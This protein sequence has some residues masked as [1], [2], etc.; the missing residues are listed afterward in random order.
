MRFIFGNDFN[1]LKVAFEDLK[2]RLDS[3]GVMVYEGLTKFA[4]SLR[5]KMAFEMFSLFPLG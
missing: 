5:K 1:G 3:V 2:I 4:K